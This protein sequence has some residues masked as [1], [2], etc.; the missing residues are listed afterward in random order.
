M[1]MSDSITY[2]S[3]TTSYF[4]MRSALQQH[5]IRYHQRCY[6]VSQ[7]AEAD[8]VGSSPAWRNLFLF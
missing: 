5:V 6:L 8:A 1:M 3:Q 4:L 7:T 2:F